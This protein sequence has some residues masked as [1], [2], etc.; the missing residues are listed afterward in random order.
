MYLKEYMDVKHL[1]QYM[2]AL[3]TAISGECTQNHRFVP[4]ESHPNNAVFSSETERPKAS[5]H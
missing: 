1:W 5:T 2:D 3:A 4:R